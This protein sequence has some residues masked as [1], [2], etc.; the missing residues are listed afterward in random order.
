[1]QLHDKGLIY[2]SNRLVNWSCKLK[3]AISDI[4]V[5]YQDIDKP[6]LL[7]VPNHQGK[8]EFGVLISFAYQV[9]DPEPDGFHFIIHIPNNICQ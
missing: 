7:T 8:Y 5:E 6:T 2:R 3:T 4:E 9:K 1:M